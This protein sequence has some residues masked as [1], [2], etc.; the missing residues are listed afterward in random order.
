MSL[1]VIQFPHPTLRHKSRTLRRV[2]GE[3]K[4]LAAEMLDLMYAHQGI[5][6]AA[7]QVDLPYRMFVCNVTGEPDQKDQEF[8][9]LNPVISQGRGSAEEEEGCLSL[10]GLRAEVR[11][12]EKVRFHAYT[13]QGEEFE[14][15]LDGL[16]ARMVQHEVDHLDGVLFIDRLS[17]AE[18]GDL[19]PVLEEF[20][21]VFDGQRRTGA[22]PTDAARVARLQELERQRT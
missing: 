1:Q 8:V 15:D 7:N 13:L 22:V 4:R 20:A 11:R 21:V 12:P 5:G 2:D 3:L 14:R 6:L 19:R 16:F 9:F 17:E 10:P 18:L